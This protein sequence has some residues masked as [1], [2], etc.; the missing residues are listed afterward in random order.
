MKYNKT[1][2]TKG[3]CDICEEEKY[4]ATINYID[5]EVLKSCEICLNKFTKKLIDL[6]LKEL[7][8]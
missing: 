4:V 2:S 7:N 5:K 6:K 3:I 1:F 8:E